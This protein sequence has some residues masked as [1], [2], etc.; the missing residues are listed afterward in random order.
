M[1]EISDSG[2]TIGALVSSATVGSW[3]SVGWEWSKLSTIML[4][5]TA[6][7]LKDCSSN[8]ANGSLKSGLRLF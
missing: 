3:M 2:S 8:I 7:D 1:D 6:V 4:G 5:S